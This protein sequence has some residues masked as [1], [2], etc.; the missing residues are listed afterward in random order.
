LR[1][2][3]AGIPS[4]SGRDK[5]AGDG[6]RDWNAVRDLPL[7]CQRRV[8]ELFRQHLS[9]RDEFLCAGGCARYAFCHIDFDASDISST[10]IVLAVV[11]GDVAGS[12]GLF[13]IDIWISARQQHRDVGSRRKI[14]LAY[15]FVGRDQDEHFAGI[16]IGNDHAVGSD[17]FLFIALEHYGLL[18]LS[19]LAQI[20]GI[21]TTSCEITMPADAVVAVSA[22]TIA[23]VAATVNLI[24]IAL[25]PIVEL[26]ISTRL[27]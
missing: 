7:C 22:R 12:G 16:E 4:E 23:E 19:L 10:S 21:D 25:L 14:N 26:S 3:Q 13:V 17:D 8:L 5:G 2:A 6:G 11:A 18:T 20:V 15:S 1:P 27:A 24:P 9:V